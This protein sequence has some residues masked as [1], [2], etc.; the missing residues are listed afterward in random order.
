M[1]S[2]KILLIVA[3][4]VTLVSCKDE[5][6]NTILHPEEVFSVS[7]LALTVPYEGG[8]VVLNVYGSEEW[9]LD[10]DEVNT[11]KRDWFSFDKTSGSGA[12]QITISITPSSSLSKNRRLVLSISG[13]SSELNAVVLQDAQVLGENEVL[14]NGLIWST[15]NLDEP[16]QFCESPDQV[17]KY[18]QFNSKIAW[19]STG[20]ISGW[21]SSKYEYSDSDWQEENSPCPDGWR[22]PTGQ[23]ISDLVDKGCVWANASQTGYSVSGL[24]LGIPAAQAATATKETIRS[25][26]GIFLPVSG[27]I[28]AAGSFDRTWLVAVRTSTSLNTTMGG[29]YLRDS[30]GYQDLWGWGDGN[31]ERAAMIRPVKKIEIED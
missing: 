18:Y 30:G 22:I 21:D 12:D 4:I 10:V 9:T 1:K 19:P 17:G 14:I 7:P 25:L 28:N 26:G 6:L 27:W 2:N 24:I 20:T 31:K 8:S 5:E 23:E 29:M 11:S 3:A 13:G 15:V 16:G